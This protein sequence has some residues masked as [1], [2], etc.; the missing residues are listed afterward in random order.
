MDNQTRSE[1]SRRKAIEAALTI[2]TRDGVGGLTFDALSRES[3]ISKGGLLHQFRTRHGVL[4]ALLDYQQQQFEQ[5]SRDYLEKEGS[6]KAEP[7]LAA[8]IAIYREAIK[9]PYSVA[10]ASLAALIESPAL[11]EEI[12]TTDEAVMQALQDGAADPD[13]SLLR[14]FAASGIAFHAMLG[15]STLSE[16]ARKRLFERLLDEKSWES[17][18]LSS[19]RRSARSAG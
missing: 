19:K 2:L 12:N 15:M 3:G 11:L 9:Q 1:I 6:T 10:R 13:L 18:T 8:R 7:I 16:S 14:Y 4:C 5:I 17:R